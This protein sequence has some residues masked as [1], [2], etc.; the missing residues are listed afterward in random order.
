MISKDFLISMCKFIS[1]ILGPTSEVLLHN[2]KNG[3]IEWINED[4]I[5]HRQVGDVN[6]TS[7]LQ[8][9]NSKCE[10]N[11]TDRIIGVLNT[12]EANTLIRTSN[13]M[14]RDDDGR[15]MYVVCINQDITG[16][17][18]VKP[19]LE[20][21]FADQGNINVEINENNDNAADIEEI[22]TNI[23]LEEV[24]HADVYKLE[25]KAAKM[26][27]LIRLYNR[28]VFKVKQAVPKVCELLDIAQPTLY[29]YLKQI[30][31]EEE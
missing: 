2:A 1:E 12:S 24:K 20:H 21:M 29:K 6:A 9:L 22:M 4:S 28:G 10:N 31:K 18:Q 13:L 15:L 5:S 30:E 14:V 7:I 16:F 27:V 25:T 8:L 19:F 11:S 23:I 17:A 3:A 26:S